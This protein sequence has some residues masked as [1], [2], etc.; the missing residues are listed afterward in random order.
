MGALTRVRRLPTWRLLELAIYVCVLV[1]VLATLT[2]WASRELTTICLARGTGGRMSCRGFLRGS[3]LTEN[4]L[5]GRLIDLADHQWRAYRN[6]I[7]LLL[8]GTGAIVLVGALLRAL[9]DRRNRGK[10]G[11]STSPPAGPLVVWHAVAGGL[12]VLVMFQSHVVFPLAFILGNYLLARAVARRP[13]IAPAAIW[14]YNLLVLLLSE[15]LGP[16]F[17]Q[18]STLLD[19]PVLGDAFQAVGLRTVF[20]RLDISLSGMQ[21]WRSGYNLTMLRLVSYAMDYHWAACRRREGSLPPGSQSKTSALGESTRHKAPASSPGALEQHMRTDCSPEMYR[22]LVLYLGYI[23]Y[24]PLFIA[25]PILSFN[26]Y[27]HQTRTHAGQTAVRGWWLVFY[28]L[29]AC[30]GLALMEVLTHYLWPWAVTRSGAYQLLDALATGLLGYFALHLIWLKFFTI[31][32]FARLFA[33]I[34]GI[35]TPENMGRCMSNNYSLQSFWREWHRSFN[36]W[37]VRYLY[38][39]LGGS[40]H[41]WRNTLLVFTFTALWHDLELSLLAW[42][43]VLAIVIV[44]ETL[45]TTWARHPRQAWLR[46]RWYYR[47]LCAITAACNIFFMMAINLIGFSTGLA[48]THRILVMLFTT[49]RGWSVV[50]GAMA[51]FFSAAQVM[52]FLREVQDGAES[53]GSPAGAGAPGATG[54]PLLAGQL[55]SQGYAHGGGHLGMPLSPSAPGS[56]HLFFSQQ[57]GP[58]HEEP[59]IQMIHLS[60]NVSVDEYG[61]PSKKPSAPAATTATAIPMAYTATTSGMGPGA[62]PTPHMS[63]ALSAIGTATTIPPGNSSSLPDH[64][65]LHASLDGAPSL[66]AGRQVHPASDFAAG[67]DRQSVGRRFSPPGMAGF[68]SAKDHDA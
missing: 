7:P 34:D 42:G 62:A 5:R 37:L 14:T 50:L 1:A 46:D 8:G 45:L 47:H 31:W 20:Y 16:N 49:A 33:L 41:R 57:P 63:P 68:S 4:I 26:G 64:H 10:P 23:L 22:S 54:S 30:F 56:Q 24:P 39:P 61:V 17:F 2:P 40:A 3:W 21:S 59:P 13:R 29:R 6:N 38:V 9:T 65:P 67:R 18:Y 36:R 11:A 51:T 27:A 58:R 12:L 60:P 43:W 48:G 53:G 19:I 15:W 52:F 32:R 66:A 25:G 28:A 44:P 35:D 55:L